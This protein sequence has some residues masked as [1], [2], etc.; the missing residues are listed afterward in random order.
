MTT[1]TGTS[2]IERLRNHH[3]KGKQ[4]LGQQLATTI[5]TFST[6]KVNGLSVPVEVMDGL[7]VL[8][9][10]IGSSFSKHL[11]KPNWMPTNSSPM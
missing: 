5:G 1:T 4:L 9:A 3:N 7:R 11:P 8:G 10:P 6:T 2:L